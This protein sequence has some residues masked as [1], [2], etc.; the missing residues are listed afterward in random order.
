MFFGQLEKLL[1]KELL[2]Q[3]FIYHLLQL[4]L[5]ERLIGA[6]V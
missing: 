4:I 5:Q 2:V 3:I 6:W 1:Q